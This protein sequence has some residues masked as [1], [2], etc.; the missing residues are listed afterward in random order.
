M[1]AHVLTEDKVAS[2]I[3]R[4]TPGRHS[5]GG[6]LFLVIRPSGSA[7]WSYRYKTGEKVTEVGLGGIDVT[8]DDAREKAADHRKDRRAGKDPKAERM[9]ARAIATAQKAGTVTLREFMGQYLDSQAAGFKNPEKAT[10]EFRRSIEMHAATLLP[11]NIADIRTAHVCAVLQPIW[12][13]RPKLARELRGR[14]KRMLS[15]AITLQLR[16][17]EN[18]KNPAQWED[19]LENLMAKTKRAK[20]KHHAAADYE[21]VPAIVAELRAKSSP[22]DLTA[23]ALEFLILTGVRSACVRFMRMAEVD[24][25]KAIWTV[26]SEA[27]KSDDESEDDGSFRVPLSQRALQILHKR[28]DF[29][30]YVFPGI[31]GADSALGMNA[32]VHALDRVRPGKGLTAHGF[33]TSLRDWAGDCTNHPREIAEHVLGHRVGGAV[34]RS[35]RRRDAFEKR[36]A[37]M[38]DWCKYVCGA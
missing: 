29:V 20:R 14:I 17:L 22:F 36:K 21:D 4:R 15:A 28:R 31:K 6:G 13:K 7:S 30:G 18:G 23:E 2:I 16:E 12:T 34:E 24:F 1:P 27:I 9:A 10:K 3:A 19:H 37:L 26:P 32:F 38:N 33:R 25:D 35:Y 5:D 11:M 8:L